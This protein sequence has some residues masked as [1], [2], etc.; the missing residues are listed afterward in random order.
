MAAQLPT[1]TL[2]RA[3][4]LASG[5]RL[6]ADDLANIH[7]GIQQLSNKG[8]TAV[9]EFST[10]PQKVAVRIIDEELESVTRGASPQAGPRHR[11]VVR[12]RQ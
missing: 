9:I 10:Y 11:A 4:L 5:S 2:N 3:G 8:H 1:I 6:L 12:S 7:V